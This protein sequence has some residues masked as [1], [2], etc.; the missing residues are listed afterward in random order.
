M[1]EM[2]LYPLPWAGVPCHAPPFGTL[3]LPFHLHEGNLGGGCSSCSSWEPGGSCVSSPSAGLAHPL[4]FHFHRA[5]GLWFLAAAS[6][7]L[8]VRVLP[9]GHLGRL[10]PQLPPCRIDADPTE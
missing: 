5:S 10:G 9:W 4:L 7:C 1:A 3:S 2:V 6:T 8:P